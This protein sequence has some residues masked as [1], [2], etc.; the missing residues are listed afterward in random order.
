[1]A[2][3]IANYERQTEILNKTTAIKTAIDN[4]TLG[5]TPRRQVFTANGTWTAPTGVSRVFVTGGGGGGGG[6][7]SNATSHL[8][9]GSGGITSFGSLLSLPGGGGGAGS[10]TQGG[11]SGG[12]AGGLGGGSGSIGQSSNTTSGGFGKGGSAGPYQGGAGGLAA[13]ASNNGGYCSGGGGM[14]NGTNNYAGGGGSGEYVDK[15]EL[16]VTPG[17][18]YTI[19]IGNGGTS[20]NVSG[21][22]G[23][24]GGQG[25]LTIEWW[26]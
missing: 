11:A 2:I 23:G 12:I 10:G 14:A 6:G 3:N 8:T 13:S 18:T 1:M 21:F 5:R 20:P 15:V 4:G 7:L 24:R 17:Q 26:E 19:T 25:I 22:T 9:G 16:I